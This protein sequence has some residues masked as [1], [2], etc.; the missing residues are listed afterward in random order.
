MRLIPKFI[1]RFLIQRQ[2]RHME[3]SLA[4]M[5]QQLAWIHAEIGEGRRVRDA[6]RRDLSRLEANLF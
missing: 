3:E 2:I 4:M 5:E 6:L 1:R